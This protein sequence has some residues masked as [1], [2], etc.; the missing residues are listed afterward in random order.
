MQ[1]YNGLTFLLDRTSRGSVHRPSVSHVQEERKKRRLKSQLITHADVRL[2]GCRRYSAREDFTFF[3]AQTTRV[4]FATMRLDDMICCATDFRKIQFSLTLFFS[5]IS[6]IPGCD[7]LRRIFFTKCHQ[8]EFS[9]DVI[10]RSLL[11]LKLHSTLP[12]SGD[13][14]VIDSY[15]GTKL[16]FVFCTRE[17]LSQIIH[18]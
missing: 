14:K 6:S 3:C 4:V 11:N 1:C 9:H 7:V 16:S 18:Q 8:L 13:T 15:T 5:T 2:T 12:N 10:M 17:E